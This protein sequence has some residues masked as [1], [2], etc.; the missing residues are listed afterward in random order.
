MC[1][2]YLDIILIIPLIWGAYRGFSKGFIISLA[3]IVAILLG[4]YCAFRFSEFTSG[5]LTVH[6]NWHPE[7][8][9]I[10]SFVITFIFVLIVV[11]ILAQVLDKSLSGVA[12]GWLNRLAGLVFGLIKYLFIVSV[13]LVIFNRFDKN[14]QFIPPADKENSV[15][16]KPLSRLFPV[17]FP[18]LNFENY[19]IFDDN[20]PSGDVIV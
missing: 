7:K 19:K 14:I 20:K 17:L 8:I 12:L 9:K 15:L 16:Y 2:N 11:R 6:F 5:L 10:I 13:I 18:Y 1:M 4:I 3:S